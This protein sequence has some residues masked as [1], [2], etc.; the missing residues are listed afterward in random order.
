M[1]KFYFTN[2]KE[3]DVMCGARST[4]GKEEWCIQGFDGET[5]AKEATGKTQA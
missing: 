2:R 3:N 4:Y 5:G 1:T